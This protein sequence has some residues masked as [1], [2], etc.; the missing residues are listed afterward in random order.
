VAEGVEN[1]ESV[2]L[3]RAMGCDV[4]QGYHIAKPLAFDAL[5]AFLAQR[6][7]EPPEAAAPAAPLRAV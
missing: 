2:T 1:A 3:L 4:A 5:M 7:G 6:Q